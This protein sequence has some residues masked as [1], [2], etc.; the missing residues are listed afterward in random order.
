M[1]KPIAT[2]LVSGGID[3]TACVHFLQQ[4]G[5]SPTGVFFD[6]GQA[7]IASE[8]NAV[9]SLSKELNITTPVYSTPNVSQFSSG[10]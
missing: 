7:A 5:Y 4:E 2:V 8:R 10:E 1:N 6:Y 3:S 9:E